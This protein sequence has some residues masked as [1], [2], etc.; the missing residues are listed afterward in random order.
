[1]ITLL[2]LL[3]FSSSRRPVLFF[4]VSSYIEIAG[5]AHARNIRPLR[6][7]NAIF[8]RATTPARDR[9]HRVRR[10]TYA[11]VQQCEKND[12]GETMSKSNI[13]FHRVRILY[14][15]VCAY[16]SWTRKTV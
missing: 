12:R 5:L 11:A 16:C 6:S 3:F 4:H 14:V 13:L 1:M 9:P 7:M 2:L 10:A 8:A 15:C